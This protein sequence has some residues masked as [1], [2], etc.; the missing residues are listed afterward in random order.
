MGKKAENFHFAIKVAR[1]NKIRSGHSLTALYVQA[2]LRIKVCVKRCIQA[3]H[4]FAESDAFPVC[5][6]SE[7]RRF[8]L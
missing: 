8:L 4:L 2:E 3:G 1:E 6:L 5:H 7:P